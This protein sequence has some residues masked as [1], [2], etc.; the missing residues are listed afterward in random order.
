[1]MEV[2]SRG[3]EKKCLGRNPDS[4]LGRFLNKLPPRYGVI[5]GPTYPIAQRAGHMQVRV[6]PVQ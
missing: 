2:R 6:T 1:V 3:G 5:G 4:I